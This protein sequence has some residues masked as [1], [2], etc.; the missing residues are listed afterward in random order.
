MFHNSLLILCIRK[1]LQC[2]EWSL[3][4]THEARH[5]M[6]AGTIG[7]WSFLNERMNL[8]RAGIWELNYFTPTWS[9][10]NWEAKIE[11]LL[12]YMSLLFIRSA[13]ILILHLKGNYKSVFVD[14]INLIYVSW[15]VS[16][17]V[18]FHFKKF[19][20]FR[21]HDWRF[22]EDIYLLRIYIN[23]WQSIAL[24]DELDTQPGNGN[25]RGMSS[26]IVVHLELILAK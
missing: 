9:L 23:L 24:L 26:C 5:L 22:T 20:D 13:R 3:R 7:S 11:C 14:F 8:G 4:G 2:T 1:R 18:S 21:V 15:N 17:L 16:G 19:K 25:S 12:H 10:Y 6:K